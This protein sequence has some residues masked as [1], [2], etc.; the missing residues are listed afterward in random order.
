[1]TREREDLSRP[2]G[3]TTTKE[4]EVTDENA[5]SVLYEHAQRE[6]MV[7]KEFHIQEL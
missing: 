6:N 4:K 7:G 3:T 1:M 5:V 2:K